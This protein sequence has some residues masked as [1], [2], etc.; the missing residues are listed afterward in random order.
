M[1]PI[2]Y[3]SSA[4]L[5]IYCL[6][7][8]PVMMKEYLFANIW[9]NQRSITLYVTVM[10]LILLPHSRLHL[11]MTHWLHSKSLLPADINCAMQIILPMNIYK[12]ETFSNGY[13]PAFKS[14]KG[15][16][17]NNSWMICFRLFICRWMILKDGRMRMENR[18]YA[19][20]R[21][22]IRIWSTTTEQQWGWT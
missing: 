22:I 8:L 4:C 5:I 18:S 15:G 3:D 12:S 6:N 1:T 9:W 10:S 11:E 17:I 19:T 7:Q 14:L 21:L 2:F 13:S 16:S 20:I